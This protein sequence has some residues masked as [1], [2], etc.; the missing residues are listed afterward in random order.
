MK[1][2]IPE[3]KGTG[4]PGRVTM[5]PRRPNSRRARTRGAPSAEV[6]TIPRPERTRRTIVAAGVRLKR[7]LPILP[8]SRLGRWATGRWSRSDV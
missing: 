8:A 7:G 4:R 1:P 5:P 6:R 3:S 2:A